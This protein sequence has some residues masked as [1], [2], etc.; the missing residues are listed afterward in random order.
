MKYPLRGVIPP[1]VTPLLEN[2][3]LDVESLEKLIM[4]L[5]NGGVHGIFL[6]GTNGEGPSLDYEVRKQLITES[7]RIIAGRVP[8]LVGI[9]DTSFS[10]VI[11]MAE[12]AKKEGADYL[13]LALPYYFPI[14]QSEMVEYL[15][16][17]I[18]QVELPVIVYDIPVCTKL[19][20]S[21][22]TIKSAKEMG[23]FGVKD[24]SGDLGALY[25]LIDAFKDEQ[26]SIIA[27]AELFMSDVLMH[28]GHGVVAGGANIFPKLFVELY[29]ASI[30]KDFDSITLLRQQVL[31]LQNEI[32]EIDDSPTKSIRAIKSALSLMD[33]CSDHM[34]PPLS[35]FCPEKKKILEQRLKQFAI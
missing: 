24:S 20:L 21:L 2:L 1:M 13:V 28:G 33:I 26:F 6:L 3:Q 30:N 32:Y 4:H 5:L 34:V 14:S 18:P 7:C 27:G 12:H 8:V 29:E 17:I 23:A 35:G 19:H 16:K 11:E 22:E 9:T 25:T 10:A 31:Q 15:E